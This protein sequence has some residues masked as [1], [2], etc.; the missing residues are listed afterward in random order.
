MHQLSHIVSGKG[1]LPDLDKVKVLDDWGTPEHLTDTGDHISTSE[2]I[3][4][5]K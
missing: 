5:M 2:K 1:V 4:R 3:L